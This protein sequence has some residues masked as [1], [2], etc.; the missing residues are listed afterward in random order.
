MEKETDPTRRTN[1][2]LEVEVGE[3]FSIHTSD[4]QVFFILKRTKGRKARLW[5]NAERQVKIVRPYW[6]KKLNGEKND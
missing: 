1:M 6:T 5:I 4:Q 3:E 2:M